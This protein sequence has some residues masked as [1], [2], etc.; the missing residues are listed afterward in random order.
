MDTDVVIIGGGFAGAA[1][2]YHLTQAHCGHVLILERESS[3]G[4]HS[5]GRNAAII[6]RRA[7]DPQ[8]QSPVAAGAKALQ[9]GTLAPFNQ[10]GIMIMGEGPTRASDHFSRTRGQGQWYPEDG[11]VDVHAL[12]HTYLSG[13]EIRY[14]TTVCHWELTDHGVRVC[15]NHGDFTAKTVINAAGAWAGVLGD[16]P[17]TPLNRHLFVTRPLEWV[18]PRWPCIWDGKEKLYFRPESGGLM[19]CVCDEQEAEPGDYEERQAI[20]EELGVRVARLQP[21]LGELTIQ[22]RWVG[23]RT[24]APDRNFVIGFDPRTRRIFHV[25][26]LGGHGVTASYE[27]GRLAA[28]MILDPHTADDNP[29]SPQRLVC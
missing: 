1:T 20:L 19:L 10:C 18:D 22:S 23:Q 29:Y 15:T 7:D 5:S 27:I 17:L 6:R 11:I 12:L 8:V 3:A 24:F 28:S 25:C 4:C 14:N 16:L 26:G 21:A 13:Q 2:A 9:R